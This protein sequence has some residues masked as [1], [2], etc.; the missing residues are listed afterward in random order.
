MKGDVG[1][2]GWLIVN[3]VLKTA[4]FI[5][6][7]EWLLNSAKSNNI[8]LIVYDNTAFVSEEE[9]EEKIANDKPS[10]VLF[11]D[12]DIPLARRLEKKG[13]RLFNSATAIEICDSKIVTYTELLSSGI[14]MPKTVIIPMVYGFSDWE[15]ENEFI[16]KTEQ[17]LGFPMIAKESKG[18]FGKQVYMLNNHEELLSCLKEHANSP[19]LLQEYIASSHGKDIRVQVVGGKVVAT[20]KRFSKTD[21]RANITNGGSM[22]KY[23]LTVAQEEMAVRVC[24]LLKLD[25]AGVDILFG[26]NDEPILCEVNSNA[27][28]I[29]LYQCTG[30]NCADKIV[31]YIKNE[32]TNYESLAD[33]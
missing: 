16:G 32:V 27:H 30:I 20:M 25:F 15:V 24:E 18:S 14:C 26:V 12:K 17:Y 1:M 8:N 6:L 11:W 7:Q 21:F 9:I 2:N 31:E 33:L 28:F 4:K 22:A 10:F 23:E 13:L 3:K 5:E 29:N 19:M